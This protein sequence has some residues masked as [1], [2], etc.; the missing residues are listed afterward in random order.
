MSESEIARILQQ[1]REEEEAARRGLQDYAS[2][3]K[4]QFITAKMENMG[5]CF[6]ALVEITGSGDVAMDRIVAAQNQADGN[7]PNVTL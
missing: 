4:H 5:K 3:S 7:T 2:V 1:F 6:Y